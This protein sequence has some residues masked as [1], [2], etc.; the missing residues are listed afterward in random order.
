MLRSN[1]SSFRILAAGNRLVFLEIGMAGATFLELFPK[2]AA[3][4][5]DAGEELW[6]AFWTTIEAQLEELSLLDPSWMLTPSPPPDPFRLGFRQYF[7]A[8]RT[9]DPHLRSQRVLA[10]NLL[11]GAYEQ[12]RL[13][14]YIW[15]ALALF[16]KRAMRKLICDRTGRVGGVRRWP[17]NV[18]AWLMT[19]R[20]TLQLPGEVLDVDEPVPPPPRR[21]DR[22]HEL[23]TDADVTL[24]VL[25]A[26]ITRY[27]LAAGG[28]RDR[29]ARNWTSY[30]QRMS[31]IGNL[32]RQ[33]QRQADLLRPPF[34]EALTARLV[35]RG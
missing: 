16:S 2:R 4:A 10:G 12:H 30:D 8:M 13:D 23:D 22:W 18:Y 17:S 26:L 25:Q 24:P 34:D 32:F 35:G 29:G 6:T 33:R 15:A 7:E 14:G 3:A 5:G 11:L 9:D 20:M 1:A 19:R 21:E 27:Q 28:H 31:T